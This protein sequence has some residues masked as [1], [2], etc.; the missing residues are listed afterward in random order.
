MPG[1]QYLAFDS[2]DSFPEAH[3]DEMLL[4]VEGIEGFGFGSLS[5]CTSLPFSG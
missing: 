1:V 4:S 5:D 2:G 3:I